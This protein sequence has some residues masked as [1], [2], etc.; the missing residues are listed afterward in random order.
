[1]NG[2]VESIAKAYSNMVPGTIRF[3]KGK[4]FGVN[5]NR[6]PIAYL[7]NP[8]AERKLYKDGDT[9][10]DHLILRFD[11][12]NGNAL[13]VISWFSVHAT[14][15]DSS[16]L[17]ISGDNLGYASLLF[18]QYMNPQSLPGKGKFVAA[19]MPLP[20]GDTSPNIGGAFCPD[21]SRCNQL[22]F[23]CK[24]EG[25]CKAVGPGSSSMDSCV[26]IAEKLF[27]NARKLF[28]EATHLIEGPVDFRYRYL[29]MENIT[30]ESKFGPYGKSG[31]TCRPAV[32]ASMVRESQLWFVNHIVGWN[33]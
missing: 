31:S 14:S 16:N 12:L 17:F 26:I 7:A 29:D 25:K 21:G 23:T 19:F 27:Q 1:V 2:T 13:G 28:E 33:D 30:V 24:N 8:E 11:D 18:E 20:S 3:N 6:S 5:I 22:D 9:N 32:G 4:L 15:L 10:K